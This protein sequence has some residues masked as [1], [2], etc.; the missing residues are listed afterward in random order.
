M[1]DTLARL[2]ATVQNNCHIADAA[3]A[4]GYTL[5]IYLLKMREYYR[6]E[7]GYAFS[8]TLPSEELGDW[9][10]QREQLWESLE[11]AAF[12]P[13]VIHGRAF[14]PFDTDAINRELLEEGLVY[15]GGYGH[16]G[17]PHFFLGKLLHHQHYDGFTTLLSTDEYARDLTA[18]PAMALGD[19]IFVRRESIRRMLWEKIEEWRWRKQQNAMARAMA[20]Y[21]FD[22]DAKHALEQMTDHET[23]AVALHEVGECLAGNQLGAAWNDLLLSVSGSKAERMVRA[24][25]DHLADA[26]ST[27][28]ALLDAEDTPS[29]HFYFA[30][31]KGMRHTL[32]PC[33]YD[34]YMRW[35]NGGGLQE[36]R[37]L[38][39]DGQ[40]V[41]SK[42]AQHLLDI[43]AHHGNACKP[44]IETAL[45]HPPLGEETPRPACRPA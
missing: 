29:L 35:E 40:E 45:E 28:P 32:F 22:A 25:R 10:Q 19:T 9:L 36:L 8:T 38:I 23:H 34:A 21:D 7:K 24:V 6:W 18:P 20:Y 26:L 16:F 44:Y 12:S 43:H 3:H 33:L 30:N 27:L 37:R 42:T 1:Q 15:S 13:L 39:A 11:S 41:W 5:C 17:A 2:T 14:D 4:R 31:L